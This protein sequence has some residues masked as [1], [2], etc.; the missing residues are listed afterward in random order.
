MLCS[1]KLVLELTT[2]IQE[3]RIPDAQFDEYTLWLE[4]FTAEVMKILLKIFPKH[5]TFPPPR[6]SLGFFLAV[7]GAAQLCDQGTNDWLTIFFLSI[8]WM[9]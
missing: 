8:P 9:V 5:K 6:A 4:W 3:Q 7:A 2:R 1:W